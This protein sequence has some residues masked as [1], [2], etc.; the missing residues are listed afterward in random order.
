MIISHTRKFIFIHPHRCAG[1]SITNSLLPYLGDDDEVYGC[2]RSGEALSEKNRLENIKKYRKEQGDSPWKH[3]TA[4]FVKAYV[5]DKIWDEYFKFTFVRSPWDIHLSNYFWWKNSKTWVGLHAQRE[6][7][8]G[9]APKDFLHRQE[10]IKQMSYPEYIKSDEIWPHTLIDFATENRELQATPADVF[11]RPDSISNLRTGLNFIGRCEKI[12][13]DFSYL[14]GRINLPNILIG[15]SN[16]SRELEGR[17]HHLDYLDK[18]EKAKS[19]LRKKH[20]FDIKYF[21]YNENFSE[22]DAKWDFYMN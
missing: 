15:L 21:K 5:G 1:T 6:A 17:K 7:V 4:L 18:D 16:A 12:K 10:K 13:S 9:H 8:A 11:G 22:Y 2:T 14:C 3:S 20:K 19:L